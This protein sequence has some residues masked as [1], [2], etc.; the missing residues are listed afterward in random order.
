MLL[1]DDYGK[2]VWPELSGE[3]TRSAANWRTQSPGT[4]ICIVEMIQSM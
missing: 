2:V 1:T 4:G 3:P